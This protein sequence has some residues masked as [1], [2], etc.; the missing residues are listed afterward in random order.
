MEKKLDQHSHSHFILK[1]ATLVLNSKT[2]L[3]NTSLEVEDGKIKQ[4]Y[5]PNE[6]TPNDVITYE[7]S[8][9][10]LT[11]GFINSHTH[12]AM[13]FFRDIGHGKNNMIESF[14]FPA[15]KS[16]SSELIKPL[17]YSYL[18]GALKSGTTLVNDHYYMSQGVAEACEDLGLR[19]AIG[20]TIATEGGA[21]PAQATFDN[22][23][24]IIHSWSYSDR[25]LPTLAPH[26]TDTVSTDDAKKIS[27]FAEAN[28]I[29]VHMHLSQTKGEFERTYQKHGKSPVKWAYENG[30][31]TENT[32]AVHLVSVNEGDIKLLADSGSTGVMCPTSQIIYEK[33]APLAKLMQANIPLVVATDCAASNDSADLLYEAKTAA[34]LAKNDGKKN[35]DHGYWLDSI[36]NR[37]AIPLGLGHKLGKLEVGFDADIVFFK[38][39]LECSPVNHAITNILF[40][41]SQ[42]NIDHVMIE[43]KFVLYDK[44]PCLISTT[45]M[46]ES[47][48]IAQQ[49]I[50]KRCQFKK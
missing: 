10:I 32:L 24:K 13:G 45:D 17:S 12:A 39:S 6:S 2:Q 20:E 30:L 38:K 18:F 36:T 8:D 22:A 34:L 29:P 1:N 19:G 33:L 43:G 27:E 21:F 49:E 25:V 41:Q 7:A 16:L 11:P 9:F 35:I 40:S 5:R 3:D 14:L 15:E 46:L 47:Y 48:K 28:D 44:E 23:Q 31:L 4:I 50:Q 26:A 37:A 42:S